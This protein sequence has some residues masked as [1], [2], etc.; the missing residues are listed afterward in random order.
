MY[1]KV[2][3]NP[4][5]ISVTKSNFFMSPNLYQLSILLILIYFSTFNLFH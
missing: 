2:L 5:E 4:V 3:K 1:L